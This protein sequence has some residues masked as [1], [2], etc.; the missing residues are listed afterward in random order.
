MFYDL[1]IFLSFTVLSFIPSQN[2]SFPKYQGID[3]SKVCYN[4]ETSNI[5]VG[6]CPKEYKYLFI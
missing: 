1:I 5:F 3:T 6:K 2:E 4:N